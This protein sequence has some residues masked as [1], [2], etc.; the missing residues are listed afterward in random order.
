M[1]F[2]LVI[3]SILNKSI[4]CEWREDDEAQAWPAHLTSSLSQT[5]SIIALIIN[6]TCVYP[7]PNNVTF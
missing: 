7:P 6:L 3:V 4:I 2:V 5:H 1:F